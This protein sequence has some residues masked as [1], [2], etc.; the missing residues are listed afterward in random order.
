MV[1]VGLTLNTFKLFCLFLCLS[2]F[3]Q[4]KY[5]C[6]YLD[7]N[8]IGGRAKQIS[9]EERS[10]EKL[11][12]NSFLKYIEFKIDKVRYYISPGGSIYLNDKLKGSPFLKLPRTGEYKVLDLRGKIFLI[13]SNGDYLKGTY[14]SLY[15]LSI[16]EKSIKKLFDL[17]FNEGFL[18]SVKNDKI[19]YADNETCSKG[20]FNVF[21]RKNNLFASTKGK[22]SKLT[23]ISNE[24][25]I[26]SE[27][28]KEDSRGVIIKDGLI[29]FGKIACMDFH[30]RLN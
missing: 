3:A 11:Y 8:C 22:C 16:K 27:V 29:D 14:G 9:E 20:G 15:L 25:N 30:K 13:I 6:N 26:A 2:S 4:D 19:T 28:Y 12:C 21:D 24:D 18:L 23:N 5:D 1:P 10:S 7:I 17:P